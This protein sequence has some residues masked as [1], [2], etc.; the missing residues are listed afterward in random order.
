[1]LSLP[2]LGMACGWRPKWGALVGR[3]PSLAGPTV[4]QVD[5][6]RAAGLGGVR[7]GPR[8]TGEGPMWRAAGAGL[9]SFGVSAG[10]GPWCSLAATL[11]P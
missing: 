7:L 3:S 5:D 4:T 9:G 11:R 6:A 8:R 10:E 2:C 1:M